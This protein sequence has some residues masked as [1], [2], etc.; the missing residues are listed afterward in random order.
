MHSLTALLKNTPADRHTH[1]QARW[2]PTL[3]H[4]HSRTLWC[5]K[6]RNAVIRGGPAIVWVVILLGLSEIWTRVS[7]SK[8]TRPEFYYLCPILHHYSPGF[9]SSTFL[10]VVILKMDLF[11]RIWQGQILLIRFW[12]YVTNIYIQIPIVLGFHNSDL[13]YSGNY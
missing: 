10:S 7:F 13:Q 4:A 2:R 6:L 9:G 5:K 12:G 11:G 3:T 1:A 8:Q